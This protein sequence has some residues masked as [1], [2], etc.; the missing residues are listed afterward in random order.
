ML[1]FGLKDKDYNACV[2]SS[3][4]LVEVYYPYFCRRTQIL[5]GFTAH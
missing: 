4:N 2:W 3:Y 5:T 1:M